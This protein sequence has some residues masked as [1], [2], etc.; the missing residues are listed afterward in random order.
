MSLSIAQSAKTYP[1]LPYEDI[2]NT[3]L[4]KKYLVTLTFIGKHRARILNMQYRK[5]SYVPNVL[6]FPLDQNV[7]EIYITPLIARTESK[8]Y[9]MTPNG[10]IGFLFIHGL[11]HLKGHP[12]GATMDRL[13]KKYVALFKLK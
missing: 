12:H 11:L 1:K 7:G 9:G 4:G 10:Y 5:A 13:E 2:K 3:I 6:S 8:K